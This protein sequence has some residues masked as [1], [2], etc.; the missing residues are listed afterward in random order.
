MA[1][2]NFGDHLCSY[3]CKICYS[4][5]DKTI[6]F[7]VICFE[8]NRKFVSQNCYDKHLENKICKYVK[9]CKKCGLI[10]K[11]RDGHKCNYFKCRKCGVKTDEQPHYCYIKSSDFNKLID[12]DKINKFIVSYDIESYIHNTEHIPNLLISK[13]KCDK[14]IG[15]ECSICPCDTKVF[16]GKT[17]IKKFVS[18]I[19][20]MLLNWLRNIN[21]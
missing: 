3:K 12:E 10:Y 18:Y 6:P 7:N 17:C 15:D 20:Q 14:C 2:N 16:F 21:R 5:C 13:I 9:M 8:C 11:S 4:T 19:F 1:Y